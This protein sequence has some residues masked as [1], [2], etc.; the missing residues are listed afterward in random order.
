[1]CLFFIYIFILF[2]LKL[3]RTVQNYTVNGEL[4]NDRKLLNL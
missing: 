1:M 3:E 4:K 2:V